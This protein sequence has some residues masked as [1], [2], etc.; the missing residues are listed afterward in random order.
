MN[1]NVIISDTGK[2]L[3]NVIFA[4]HD[5]IHQYSSYPPSVFPSH[6]PNLYSLP[7]SHVCSPFPYPF[8]YYLFIY[9]D[10]CTQK[11]EPKK[12]C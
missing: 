11:V 1:T 10:L 7:M 9:L 6:I 8:R 3:L 12:V 2:T 5:G 4:L